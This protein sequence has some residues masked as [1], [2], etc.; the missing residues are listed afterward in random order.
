MK[1]AIAMVLLTLTA[2][3]Q[4]SAS[5]WDGVYTQEQGVR[6]KAV[7]QKECASCHG[8]ALEGNGTAPPL[9]GADFKGNWNG[10]TADD[11]FEK[12]QATMPA[13]Q[14]GRLSREQN[15]DILAFL[16]SSNGFPAGSRELSSEAESLGK[17]RFEAARP[18]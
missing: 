8:A 12:I 14:P 3:A 11:L 5:V 2:G 10:Q 17:I 7:Y 1:T 13:D 16:L 15:A 18:K 9:I 4:Q 6:G